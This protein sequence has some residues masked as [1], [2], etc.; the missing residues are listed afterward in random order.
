MDQPVSHAV[1]RDRPHRTAQ[2]WWRRSDGSWTLHPF[3][4]APASVLALLANSTYMVDFPDAAPAIA[5]GL[6]AA[7]LFYGIFCAISGSREARAAVAASVWIV[8]SCYFLNLFGSLNRAIDGGYPMVRTLPLAVLAMVILSWAVLRVRLSLKPL[9]TILN[10]IAVVLVITPTFKIVAYD[11]R[12]WDARDLYDGDRA[13]AALEQLAPPATGRTRIAGETPPDIYHF[14]FDRY[15]SEHVL[16]SYFDTDNREI[17][18]FLEAQGFYLARQSHSNYLKTGHSLASTFYMDYLDNLDA[19]PPAQRSNWRP[20]YEM[21]DDHRVARFLKARD[22]TFHQYGSWWTGTFDNAVADINRP[23][24]FSEFN[25]LYLRRTILRPLFH[26]LPDTPLTMMLD[27]DNGQCQRVSRQIEE[28]KTIGDADKP[29]Y[30]FAHILVPHGPYV[31]TAQGECLTQAEAAARGPDQGYIDHIAY[32]NM[33]IRDLVTT[34]KKGSATPPVILIQADEGPF[35][36]RDGSVPWHDATPGELDM[37]TGILNAYF[38]PSGDYG[39][40]RPD[41]SPVN[42]YRAVFNAVFGSGFPMLDDRVMSFPHDWEIYGYRDVTEKVRAASTDPEP[43]K[44][45]ILE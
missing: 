18:D 11:W 39:S 26:A 3:L 44:I 24:G 5:W 23:M 2:R 40:M 27:W 9:N 19:N 36:T 16:E 30:L 6:A 29:V 13:A 4:F 8:G 41:I 10:A 21:L 17:G 1:E 37:K 12:N 14:V 43:Q 22:Y 25:M 28:I 33:M 42:S 20:V 38:F 34:L 31:F 15:G 45:P 32:A 7:M 35:P